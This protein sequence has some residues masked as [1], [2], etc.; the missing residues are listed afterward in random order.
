LKKLKKYAL[1]K[2]VDITQTDYYYDEKGN[3]ESGL[4]SNEERIRYY[5][6][7]F[8]DN[9]N[10]KTT[11]I[12]NPNWKIFKQGILFWYNGSNPGEVSQRSW[13][14]DERGFVLRIPCLTIFGDQYKNNGFPALL[15]VRELGK[16]KSG[17]L[18]K[19]EYIRH[20]ASIDERL[21]DIEW[22]SKK[23]EVIWRGRPTGKARPVFGRLLL[24][25]NYY[26]KYDVGFVDS[27]K[28]ADSEEY[29]KFTRP[30]LSIKEQLK[31]KYILVPEGND[32][33]SS[34]NWV[35]KSNSLAIMPKPTVESW[36]MEG[37]LIPYVH[38]VPVADD[39]GDLDEVISWCKSHDKEC[40]EISKN[41]T[42]WM[43][44]FEN[45]KNELKLHNAIID[46]YKNK[47]E[48]V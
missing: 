4:M 7:G 28:F 37:L 41:A 29:S 10:N 33:S 14:G 12:L 34:L 30:K 31:Y 23:N 15:K 20:W 38:Y 35:L 18:C 6:G 32:K 9:S 19:L 5:L 8:Y 2:K 42:L 21:P 22:K 44:Q 16:P 25:R 26:Q 40:R 17:I 36:L 11:I 47:Y 1:K 24:V 3:I 45:R 13:W 46:Y 43:K 39:W 27:E 48:F